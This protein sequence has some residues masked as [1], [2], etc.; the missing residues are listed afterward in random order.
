MQSNQILL[1]KY[2]NELFGRCIWECNFNEH[3][4]DAENKNRDSLAFRIGSLR[5]H[6]ISVKTFVFCR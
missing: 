5:S 1:E 2:N 4:N 6:E 3:E